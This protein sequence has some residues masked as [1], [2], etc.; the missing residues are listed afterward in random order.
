MRDHGARMWDAMIQTC[1]HALATDLPP[2]AHGARPRV[3]VTLSLDALK[4]RVD[5][6][7]VTDDGTELS[8]PPLAAW[9]ATPT[10]SPSSSAPAAR[11]ST[12]AG[13]TGWSPP[14]CGGPW[15]AGTGTARSPA[16]PGHR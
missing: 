16:A 4:G 8:P 3:A 13:R 1:E 9:P 6:S 2:D 11:S 15:C 10:S 7:P 12:S 5:W 14:P